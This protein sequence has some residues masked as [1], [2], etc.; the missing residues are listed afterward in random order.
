[1]PRRIA[2][3]HLLDL[4]DDPAPG[5]PLAIG[6]AIRHF[7]QVTE[8]LT[9][10]SALLRRIGDE[11]A[12]ILRGRFTEVLQ[13]QSRESAE[14]LNRAAERYRHVRMALATYLPELEAARAETWRAVQEA[15]DADASVRSARNIAD[16]ARRAGTQQSP[17]PAEEY[18]I[19][20]IDEAAVRLSSLKSRVRRAVQQLDD[21]A[22]RASAEIRM[23]W[24]VDGLRT[25]KWDPTLRDF[26]QVVRMLHVVGRAL[27]VASATVTGI[28]VLAVLGRGSS[29]SF[30]LSAL[31]ALN[32][33]AAD[34][35]VAL[36]AA[37]ITRVGGDTGPD[38][39][40]DGAAGLVARVSPPISASLACPDS[41][42]RVT[43]GWRDLPPAPT[44][45]DLFDLA[46]TVDASVVPASTP[47]WW[48]IGR[49]EYWSSSWTTASDP[50]AH[51]MRE[52]GGRRSSAE[53]ATDDLRRSALL[54]GA[55]PRSGWTW[56]GATARGSTP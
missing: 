16:T 2:E 29:G 9:A 36:A 46:P 6:R 30:G 38:D 54:A 34:V 28:G 4:D 37:S 35:K 15:T 7:G 25:N 17:R 13:R 56:F 51:W 33:G 23:D 12:A 20:V 22:Q 11:D 8:T 14:D 50:F 5:D 31:L 27:A 19:R 18:S 24:E 39:H 45:E 21:A 55:R 41:V 10:Q 40:P 49:P 1:M 48:H 26:A 53:P 32:G 52:Q 47:I 3:W 43:R 42:E 44:P